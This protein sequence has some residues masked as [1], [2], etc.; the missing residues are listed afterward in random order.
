MPFALSRNWTRSLWQLCHYHCATAH[1]P[2]QNRSVLGNVGDHAGANHQLLWDLKFGRKIRGN[3]L[4]YWKKN[5]VFSTQPTGVPISWK[6]VVLQVN[7][8]GL[9]LKNR[10][11]DPE[12]RHFRSELLCFWSSI[13]F[14]FLA[15]TTGFRFCL[16]PFLAQF[17][18]FSPKNTN[19]RLWSPKFRWCPDFELLFRYLWKTNFST[20]RFSAVKIH[21]LA[22]ILPWF[23]IF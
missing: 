10:N 22:P 5:P 9:L 12:I 21:F 11:F 1:L 2:A 19:F 20:L 7:P 14:S 18:V 4:K 6:T 13:K 8:L 16:K 17:L 15:R 23:S 3:F